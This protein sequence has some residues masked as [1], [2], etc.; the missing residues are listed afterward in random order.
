MR[1]N[2]GE[3]I[4]ALR[5]RCDADTYHGKKNRRV[6]R[7][8]FLPDFDYPRELVGGESRSIMFASFCGGSGVP[9]FMATDVGPGR[10]RA[11]GVRLVAVGRSWATH[12]ARR[13]VPLADEGEFV[14]SG[15]FGLS[16]R[17]IKSTPALFGGDGRRAVRRFVARVSM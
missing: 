9:V 6:M 15:F 7:S 10:G 14:P 2:D 13:S 3:D 17:K 12:A 4:F 16:A 11:G 8:L 1:G 5:R